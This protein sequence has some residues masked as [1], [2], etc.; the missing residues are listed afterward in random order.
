MIIAIAAFLI[1][2]YVHSNTDQENARYILSAISQGL[3]AILAL[4]ITV[5]FIVSQMTGR[6]TA[7]KKIILQTFSIQFF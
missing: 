3:A 1:L 7:T 4:V 5:M 2:H 6:Y